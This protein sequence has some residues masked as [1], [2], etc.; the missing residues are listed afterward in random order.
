[1]PRGYL[2]T[3]TERKTV[4]RHLASGKSYSGTSAVTG[5]PRGTVG[6][7]GRLAIVSGRLE[8]RPFGRPVPSEPEK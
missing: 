4:L 1:M 7:I 8:P 6:H 5:V 3:E 2:L